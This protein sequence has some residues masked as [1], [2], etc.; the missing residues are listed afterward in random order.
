MHDFSLSPVFMVFPPCLC[1]FSWCFYK[2]VSHWIRAL[3]KPV[4]SH[5]NQ[6]HLQEPY[7]QMRSHLRFWWTWTWE[8]TLQPRT[9][10]F[11]I[12]LTF[13]II[14]SQGSSMLWDVSGLLWLSN[15]PLWGDITFHSFII[16]WTFG[17]FPHFG[18]CEYS[19]YENLQT[20]FRVDICFHFSWGRFV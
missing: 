15:I 12:W 18:C 1:I 7:F 19:F 11:G 14:N 9:V 8:D 13:L 5:L 16:S 10:V 4:W 6:L 20:S 2:D 17:L 3:P